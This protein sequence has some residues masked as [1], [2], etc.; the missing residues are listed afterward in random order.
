MKTTS[1]NVAFSEWS[2]GRP[3]LRQHGPVRVE[4]PVPGPPGGLTGGNKLAE[5]TDLQTIAD[6]LN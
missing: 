1:E 5:K 4:M 6:N 2:W 3:G